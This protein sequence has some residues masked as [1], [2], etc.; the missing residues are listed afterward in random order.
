MTRLIAALATLFFLCACGCINLGIV[1]ANTAFHNTVSALRF[2]ENGPPPEP[3]EFELTGPYVCGNLTIYLVHRQDSAVSQDY[4]TLAEGMSN[5]QVVVDET[6]S[7]N[8]L[9]IRNRSAEDLFVQ[10]GEIAK[11]GQ[12]DRTLADDLIVAN[13]DSVPVRSFCVEHGRWTARDNE[14]GTRF[15]SSQNALV[16][17]Q[18]K[19]AAQL[20]NDQ[21][22]VWNSVALLQERLA[23]T[24]HASPTNSQSPTSLQLTLENPAVQSWAAEYVQSLGAISDTRADVVGYACLINGQLASAD[25]Y[26]THALFRKLWPK[27]LMCTAI[28]AIARIQEP[29]NARPTGLEQVQSLML[30]RKVRRNARLQANDRTTALAFD[31][32]NAILFETRDELWPRQWVHRCYL[33]K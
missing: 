15:A 13:G 21:G 25:L 32:D 12:Q 18:L 1:P 29:P 19:L 16:S 30:F 23:R 24:L 28:D 22:G 6:R 9:S 10:A 11:G 2:V 33:L 14:S 27:L 31:T 26:A 4:L 20:D 3:I 17:Q 7:V 8:R 5:G